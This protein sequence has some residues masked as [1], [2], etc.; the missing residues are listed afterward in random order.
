MANV[1]EH[2]PRNWWRWAA[3]ILAVG[4]AASWV[5]L[6]YLILDG[7]ISLDYCRVE[8]GHL[9]H[10]VRVLVESGKGRL[11]ADTLVKAIR[12]ID[13]DYPGGLDEQNTL[14]LQSVTLQFDDAHMLQGLVQA[15]S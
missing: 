6:G 15:G 4:L 1:A 5:V 7:A 11:D 12:R 10:D 2:A 8:Q 3:V 13:P 9:R 14:L